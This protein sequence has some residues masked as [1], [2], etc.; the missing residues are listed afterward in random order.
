MR[1]GAEETE[2]AHTVVLFMSMPLIALLVIVDL[3]SAFA[4]NRAPLLDSIGKW[5]FGFGVLLFSYGLLYL[6]LIRG[7][8]L[9]V[10]ARQFETP[11]SRP[12]ISLL[13]VLI[14]LFGFPLLSI[15]V[16]IGVAR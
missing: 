6:H 11:L 16:G 2:A 5:T 8:R 14:Y 10:I 15:I 4:L 9:D 13:V 12:V 1:K 7:R 3:I